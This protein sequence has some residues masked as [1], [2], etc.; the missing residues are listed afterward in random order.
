[1]KK[2]ILL[3]YCL[4]I[5]Y[6]LIAGDA[7]YAVSK[8][9]PALLKNA[10]AVIRTEEIKVEIQ[11]TDEVIH[12]NHYVITILNENGD[13]WAD[14]YEFYDK[15]RSISSIEGILYDAA[16][17]ELKTLKSKDIRDVSA[18]SDNN[19]M[20]DDRI[21]THNFYYKT[22]PYTIEYSIVVKMKYSMFL[23]GW[24]PQGGS[25]LSVESS[26]ISVSFPQDYSIRY[27]AFN[28]KGDPEVRQAGNKKIYTW[29]VK[30][31]PA[32]KREPYAP[33]WTELV[34]HVI[35]GPTD[36]EVQNYKGR[37]NSW[38]DFG[39]FNYVLKQ[40]RDELPEA[41]KQSVHALTDNVSDKRKKIE[42]LY[43][44]LQKN[45]RYISIQL[46]IGGWQPYDANYVGTKGYGDCKALSNYMYSLLKEAGVR[47]YY[48]LVK[49]GDDEPD[50]QL[51]FPS[52]Q[53]NHVILCVPDKDTIWLECTSQTEPPGYMG[54][55]TGNRHA[56]L[57]DENDSK[58][59]STPRYTMKDNVQL[60]KVKAAL[61]E[62][63][64]LSLLVNTDYNAMERDD[65]HMLINN[66]SKTR[67]ADILAK[68]FSFG[69]YEVKRFDYS[70]QKSSLPVMSETLEIN[71]SN[72]A[73]VT[74]KRIFI[75]PNVMTR[76]E[77]KFVADEERKFDIAFYNEFQQ[78]DSVEIDMPGGYEPESVPQPVQVKSKYGSY[79]NSVKLDGNKIVYYRHF[80]QFKGRY[81]INEYAEIALFY[82]RIYKAD[83]ARIVLLR[84]E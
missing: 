67:L 47:S 12:T 52:A 36:F 4:L 81:P 68:R 64:S 26:S 31:L 79:I 18:V 46:G 45:T 58:L 7:P 53:F 75:L 23:P 43:E 17:N 9:A 69:T 59:V 73:S 27:K 62:D 77:K 29:S 56:L 57:V 19:L 84:K 5:Q 41:V 20:D 42:L 55:F 34:T 16:G 82:E 10:N 6:W 32:I 60:R 15:L 40:G 13:K 11:S 49:A 65:L 80:E 70:E 2:L 35:F 22:Y 63:A 78:T 71:V 33:Y 44:Y 66:V 74:G 61:K 83:R 72:Y 3:G 39:R 25:L 30:D 14:M 1:M 48:T 8:I 54:G 37:M 76:M 50:L 21:K 28:Y 38:S 51:D 24:M